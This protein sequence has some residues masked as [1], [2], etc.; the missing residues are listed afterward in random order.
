[1]FVVYTRKFTFKTDHQL[2]FANSQV[3]LCFLSKPGT[4]PSS[5]QSPPSPVPSPP[6]SSQ[7]VRFFG[8]LPPLP[9]LKLN[10]QV[11]PPR[12][13][14]V[15]PRKLPK[16]LNF[17]YFW[18]RTRIVQK[19]CMVR[20]AFHDVIQG[21]PNTMNPFIAAITDGGS[22]EKLRLERPS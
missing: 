7:P 22:H 3:I 5:S 20:K 18:A 15:L 9:P 8:L 14:P 10:T 13:C 4:S 17:A 21:N 16:R 11:T 19:A 12:E 1:M 2:V 6:H